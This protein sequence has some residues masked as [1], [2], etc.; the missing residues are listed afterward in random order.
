MLRV[1]QEF[2]HSFTKHSVNPHTDHSSACLYFIKG[3]GLAF[4]KPQSPFTWQLLILVLFCLE[5]RY[6]SNSFKLYLGY[7]LSLFY[8]QRSIMQPVPWSMA[9]CHP[10]LCLHLASNI[11]SLYSIESVSPC[12][13]HTWLWLMLCLLLDITSNSCCWSGFIFDVPVCI[14][15]CCA[16]H[17]C[18]WFKSAVVMA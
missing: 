6:V 14:Q 10:T 4:H 16:K 11:Q 2:L 15:V 3:Y 13:R 12:T 9:L 7:I 17:S 5:V 1:Q 18:L 8:Q